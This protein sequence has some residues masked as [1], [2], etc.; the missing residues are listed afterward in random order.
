MVE[1]LPHRRVLGGGVPF[2]RE[3]G[4]ERQ[5]RR[6]WHWVAEVEEPTTLV[7]VPPLLDGEIYN[8][9]NCISSFW[10]IV[11][12]LLHESA[13]IGT[14]LQDYLE[15]VRASVHVPDD[16]LPVR[17]TADGRVARCVPPGGRW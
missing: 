16:L 15:N 7:L 9:D 11:S 4:L 1:P 5:L 12:R 6:D 10:I 2:L 3:K 17:I 8:Y 14:G 13:P